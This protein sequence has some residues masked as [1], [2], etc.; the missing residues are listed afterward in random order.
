MYMGQVTEKGKGPQSSQPP[1][2]TSK[3]LLALEI[4]DDLVVYE[5]L[6]D[7]MSKRGR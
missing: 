4:H 3:G 1:N 6:V 5:I 2:V 7:F